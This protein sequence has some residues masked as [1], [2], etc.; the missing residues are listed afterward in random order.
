[1]GAIAMTRPIEVECG[2][3]HRVQ[4]RWSSATPNGLTLDQLEAIGWTF[5]DSAQEWRCPFCW[6]RDHAS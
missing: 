2:V 1:M 6:E 3:C 4:L 5:D